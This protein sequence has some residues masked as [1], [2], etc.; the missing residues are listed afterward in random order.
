VFPKEWEQDKQ[1]EGTY[2]YDHNEWR[3]DDK[4]P[5]SIRGNWAGTL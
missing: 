5:W 1:T 4:D 2:R 3:E